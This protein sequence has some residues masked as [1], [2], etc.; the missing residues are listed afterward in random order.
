MSS[1][2]LSSTAAKN[3]A[4]HIIIAYRRRVR[5]R[6]NAVPCRATAGHDSHLE[7]ITRTQS[8]AKWDLEACVWVSVW[9]LWWE[10]FDIGF[11]WISLGS[12]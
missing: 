5:A 2:R 10:D 1:G 9:M 4:R 8:D 7:E 11:Q 6:A 3:T 12:F